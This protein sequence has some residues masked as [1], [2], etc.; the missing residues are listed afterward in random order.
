[1]RTSPTLPGRQSRYANR[2]VMDCVWRL[3]LERT[4]H[5]PAAIE[6]QESRLFLFGVEDPQRVIEHLSWLIGPQPAITVA[7]VQHLPGKATCA[8]NHGSAHILFRR[9]R[10][11]ANAVEGWIDRSEVGQMQR[12]VGMLLLVVTQRQQTLSPIEIAVG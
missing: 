9:E 8:G 2:R 7:V 10:C 1:M 6:R 4:K 5:N 12:F 11:G 3:Q